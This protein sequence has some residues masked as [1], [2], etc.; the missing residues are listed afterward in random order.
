MKKSLFKF[1][2]MFILLPT[3][4][5]FAQREANS[6][7]VITELSRRVIVLKFNVGPSPNQIIAI[8]SRKGLIVIDTHISYNPALRMREAIE[9][10]FNRCDFAYVI[11]THE[12]MDHTGGNQVFP[13]AEIIAH[14][15]CRQL[16]NRYKENPASYLDTGWFE[17]RIKM[18]QKKLKSLGPQ[19][20][21][22]IDL[23][24]QVS[25]NREVIRDFQSDYQITPPTIGFTDR[26]TL[27]LGDLTSELIF[28]DQAH[29]KSDIVIYIPEEKIL[30]TGDLFHGNHMPMG[31]YHGQ[32]NVARWLMILDALLEDQN[33]IEYVVCG[34][35]DI[36]T[37]EKLVQ[38]RD[39]MR[40]LWD[41]VNQLFS[42]GLGVEE[43]LRRLPL[44]TDSDLYQSVLENRKKEGQSDVEAKIESYHERAIKAY[45]RRLQRD[46][47]EEVEKALREGG[48]EEA[49][50][51]MNH[52]LEIESRL[53][54]FNESGFNMLGYQLLGS[55]KH[56]EAIEIFQFGIRAFPESANLYDSLGEAYMR[57]G[58]KKKAVQNYE[59][60]LELN[61]QN[62]N[63]RKIL[64][65][66]RK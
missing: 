60:S 9:K 37:K 46:A 41:G 42:E 20:G 26:L 59:K 28:F 52:L 50:R 43:A 66:L 22:A 13:E 65:D 57:A 25:L 6:S 8:A 24:A 53:V 17:E 4:I 11:N 14:E 51:T 55:E 63:A 15:N 33:D 56:Q 47:V 35:R 54:Y 62:E 29:S 44:H 38:R 34:H 31:V 18:L 48:I 16:M 64:K 2:F 21:I 23:K 19:S 61:P 12:D 36:W 7:L 3:V 49:R 32:P 30:M 40:L 1:L 45:W 10:W 5:I 27:D 39:Y 58:N